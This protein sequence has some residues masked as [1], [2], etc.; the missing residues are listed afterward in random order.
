MPCGRIKILLGQL[1]GC[2]DAGDDSNKAI[3]KLDSELVTYLNFLR[4]PEQMYKDKKNCIDIIKVGAASTESYQALDC[5]VC[6]KILSKAIGNLTCKD[7][8]TTLKGYQWKDLKNS[9][10]IETAEYAIANQID[11]QPAFAWWIPYVQ[12]KRKAILKK[13]KSK[14]WQRTHKY[15]ILIPKS[16]KDAYA[17]DLVSNGDNLWN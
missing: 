17:A 2:H 10:P 3:L 15:G 1:P 6:F 8:M 9:Y 12:K 11:D 13:V 7:E 16:V 5:G 4:P 14:Y